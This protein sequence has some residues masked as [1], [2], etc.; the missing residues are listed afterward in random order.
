VHIRD[1]LKN[2]EP[3][4]I[5]G[6]YSGNVSIICYDSR[7]CE[8][9]SLFVAIPGLKVDGH[10]YITE[11]VSRGARFIVHERDYSPPS[12]I[13]AIKVSD[14]R[15]VLGILGRN[16]YRD[17]SSRLYLIGVM[18]TNGKTTV[19][20]LLESILKAAGCPVGVMGTVNYRFGEKVLPA[21]KTTPES[22]DMQKI[23]R[24]MVDEGITHVIAEISSH[25]VDLKRVDDCSFDMGIFTNLSRDH[26]DYHGTMDNY[27]LAKKRFFDDVLPSGGKRRKFMIVNGDDPWGQRLLKEVRTGVPSRTFGIEAR[28]DM[29]ADPF[30]LSLEGIKACLRIEGSVFRANSPL[31]GKFNLY[32]ILAAAMAALSLNIPEKF[33]RTGVKKLKKVPGRLEKISK[34]NEPWVFVDYAHTDDALRR[35]LQNLSV[36]RKRKIITVFGCGGDRDRGKRPLMGHAAASLSDLTIVTSDNPRTENPLAIIGEIEKGIRE[37]SIKKHTPE[38]LSRGTNEKSYVVIPDRKKAIEKAL[39]FSEPSDIV[40]IAGKG[41]ENYQIIGEARIPFDDRKIAKAALKNRQTLPILHGYEILSATGGILIQGD[42]AGSFHGI[43]TD[44]RQITQGSLFIPLKGER[45]DGHDFLDAA[46]RNGATGILIQKESEKK[47]LTWDEHVTIIVVEDTLRALGDIAHYWRKKFT[48]SVVAITGSSG[49]TTTKEMIAGIAGLMKNV[50]KAQGNFNNLVG[51]PVTLLNLRDQHDVMILEMGTN[52]RGEIERL[53]RIADPDIGVI[54]N[55]G[56]AHLEGLKSI[57]G[58]REEKCD[59]F[60]NMATSGIAIINLDDESIRASNQIWHGK[61]ITFGLGQEADVSAEDMRKRGGKGISFTLRIAGKR[62]K[63]HLSATGEHNIYNALAAAASSWALGI[64]HAIICQGLMTFKPI[65]GRMEICQLKNGA[66]IINDTYNANPASVR[67]ALKTLKYLRGSHSST[68]IHG[69][70]LELGDQAYEMHESIGS[71][72]ADTEVDRIFLRG[73]LSQ[74]TAAGALKRNMPKNRIIFFETPEEVIPH[75]KST[76]KEGDWVLIKGSRMMK[77]E[78]IVRTIIDTFGLD[79]G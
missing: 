64:D 35:V 22:Y 26:L 3:I 7:H 38:A 71:L 25:A 74:A 14:S 30:A 73:R 41:H 15:R 24:S 63:I 17:P 40:L 5:A 23:L 9:K 46:L 4:H 13:T 55:I 56:P 79:T 43:S 65:S 50:I 37:I 8:K 60:R 1:L 29:T 16:F 62:Q 6:H 72:M 28:C 51:V 69:D 57:G 36:F 54:T 59:L 53:T 10:N 76:L 48:A 49:K 67:E 21:P 31:I 12:G 75:L 68:V 52:S 34:S 32:N 78:E 19:T 45:Y 44:S 47:R 70:M 66:F 33:I 18:G 39:S 2:V 77:M 61:R 11:A 20:Y 27:F 58:V 42:P